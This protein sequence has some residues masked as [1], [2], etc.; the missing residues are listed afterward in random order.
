M[1]IHAIRALEDNAK[2][3]NREKLSKDE[4]ISI[5]HSYSNSISTMLD[6]EMAFKFDESERIKL[7]TSIDNVSKKLEDFKKQLTSLNLH[8]PSHRGGKK[9]LRKKKSAK[10]S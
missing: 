1:L 5:I 10:N 6:A 4:L 9:T 8:N 2:Y 7:L 3:A